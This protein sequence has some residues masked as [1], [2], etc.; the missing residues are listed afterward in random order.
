MFIDEITLRVKAGRGG[1]GVV[2][3]L[4]EK[5]KEF[6]GP[7]GGDGGAGGSVY[8]EA[9]RDIGALARYR[10]A[11]EFR[12]EDGKPGEGRSRHGRNGKDLILPMPLG[13]VIT[14]TK[15][16]NVTE[17][18]EDGE[19]VLVLRGGPGGFGNEHYKSS[20]NRNPTEHMPGKAG[21]EADLHIELRLIADIGLV[22]LP[23]AGKTSLLNAL[24][25]ARGKVGAYA[26]TTLEP[27]L[28]DWYGRIIADIPGLIE[29][30]A[31]G[32]GLGDKFLRHIQRTKILFHCISLENEDLQG[33]Y[34]TIRQ[35]LERYSPSLLEKLEHIILTK[36]DLVS[37]EVVAKAK[38]LFTDQHKEVLVMSTYDEVQ[39]KS[40]QDYIG[41]L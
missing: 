17:L 13:A 12:A 35:E 31:E 15:T 24:T 23:N 4:H 28:G 2:R 10:F 40:L 22:G 39:M 1:D 14:N 20:V 38:K 6:G 19:R 18:L 33:A 11:D 16:G 5:G 9:V 25:N 8:V 26:F 21:E 7:A 29:G 3:W 27:N 34:D 30:A 41:V 32:K 36:S 37:E